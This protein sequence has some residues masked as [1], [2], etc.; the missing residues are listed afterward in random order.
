MQDVITID[1]KDVPFKANAL[2]VVKYQDRHGRDL[3]KDIDLWRKAAVKGETMTTD[4]LIVFLDF[5]HTMAKQADD[6]IPDTP[7]EWVDQFDV[8]PID[9]I[10]PKLVDLWLRSTVSS[11]EL[12]KKAKA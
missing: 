4:I 11:A 2:T 9:E 10:M 5:A 7:N 3:Y 1:G 12:K 8:F 6:S